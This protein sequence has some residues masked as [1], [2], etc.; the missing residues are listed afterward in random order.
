MSRWILLV[1]NY[2]GI[3]QKAVNMLSGVISGYLKYV[4]PVKYINNVRSEAYNKWIYFR[5][6]YGF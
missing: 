1:D 4:L 2:E 5:Y 3:S 6:A